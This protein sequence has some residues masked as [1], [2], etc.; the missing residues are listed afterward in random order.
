MADLSITQKIKLFF[1]TAVSTPFFILYAVIGIFLVVFMMFDIK[2]KKRFSKVIYIL[3]GLFLISFFFIKYFNVILK[4]IDSFVEII[5]K[6]LYFPNLGIYVVMLIITNGTF[7]YNLISKKTSKSAKGITGVINIIIDFIFIMIVG[8]ISSEKI[9]VTSEV[10]L[11]SDTTILTLL[12]MSMALFSSQ[13]LILLLIM[14]S[15]KFKRFDKKDNKL[16]VDNSINTFSKE[17]VKVFKV[18]NFG[19]KSD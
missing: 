4:V 16:V 3:S 9:D 5:L 8:I 13:Y 6:A 14:A 1:N 7:I 2:K 12:Q 10:K 11:Y 15:H 18:L 19:D 17:S